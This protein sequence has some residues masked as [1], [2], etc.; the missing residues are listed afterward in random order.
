MRTGQV[1]AGKYRLERPLG[2]G[3]MASV[4]AATNVFTE[5]PFAIKFMLPQV[6]RTQEASARF[7]LE[8]KVSAR[9]DHPNVIEILDVGQ[10]EDG[11]L[12]LVMELLSGLS[13][14]AALRREAMS[15]HTFGEL[16]LSVTGAL[17]AA[18]KRGV[19][20]RDLKPTNIFLHKD[21]NGRTVPKVLDFGVS[22]IL[23]ASPNPGLTVAGTVLGSPLYMSPEQ[24]A[25]RTDLDGRTDIFAFGA[26]VFE[27]LCAYR[28]YEASNFN[29]L[30]VTIATTPPKDIDEGAP[31]AP[32]GLRALVRGCL[33]TDR[34]ARIQSFEEVTARLTAL[35]PEL[36]KGG[37][38]LPLGKAPAQSDTAALRHST[39][40]PGGG[41]SVPWSSPPPPEPAA[42]PVK[43]GL[44]AAAGFVVT[45]LVL[46]VGFVAVGAGPS[47]KTAAARP[48][49]GTLQ[50]TSEPGPCAITVDGTPKGTTPLPPLEIAAGSYE[51][52]CRPD[53]GGT[54]RTARVSV[55]A[56]GEGKYTFAL[57]P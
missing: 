56:G 41:F 22:K 10:T 24:A 15:L 13:L 17:A 51:V 25:G 12:F 43:M 55:P 5:R 48:P 39:P 35:L 57:E 38:R 28:V 8:A 49:V 31:W 42:S 14:E 20:H 52:A 3:G 27:A 34:D 19:I 23:E 26:I 32:E 29:A 2:A 21:K 40:P 37:L 4:W 18:H 6:A 45:A 7:L 1:I 16:L 44:M 30:I 47:K 46:A 11:S 9:I 50:V 36:A 54:T 53:G 33:A